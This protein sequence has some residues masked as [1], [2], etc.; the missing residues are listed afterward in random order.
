MRG[1]VVMAQCEG[2]PPS[3]CGLFENIKAYVHGGD[4]E[5]EEKE[6]SPW[7][8]TTVTTISE[9]IDTLVAL[10]LAAIFGVAVPDLNVATR[11]AGASIVT[12][13]VVSENCSNEHR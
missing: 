11:G 13:A 7:Q 2:T 9:I 6:H 3:H 10:L 8:L 1:V 4:S 5:G 12:L